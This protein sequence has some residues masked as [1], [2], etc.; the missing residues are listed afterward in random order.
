MHHDVIVTRLTDLPMRWYEQWRTLGL[1]ES[2]RLQAEPADRRYGYPAFQ[3][4]RPHF[5]IKPLAL[6]DRLAFNSKGSMC[7]DVADAEALRMNPWPHD[8][9][10][11]GLAS[12]RGPASAGS[13]NVKGSSCRSNSTT[14]SLCC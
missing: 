2:I 12:V 14:R 8:R 6:E 11:P 7:I 5:S 4:A 3:I 9:F 1:Q 13:R 10:D